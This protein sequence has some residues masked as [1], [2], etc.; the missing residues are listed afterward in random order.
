M[1][2]LRMNPEKRGIFEHSAAQIAFCWD[3]QLNVVVHMIK[4]W[5]RASHSRASETEIKFFSFALAEVDGRSFEIG[6]PSSCL[7]FQIRE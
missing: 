7:S 3:Y 5:Q 6:S 2:K 1:R 4:R